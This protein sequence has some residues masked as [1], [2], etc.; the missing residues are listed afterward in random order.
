MEIYAATTA[1][2]ASKPLLLRTLASSAPTTIHR[3]QICNVVACKG[4]ERHETL[5]QWRNR[6]GRSRF[7]PVHLGSNAY[8]Q[9]S[10]LSRSRRSAPRRASLPALGLQVRPGRAPHLPWLQDF[11]VV[12][13]VSVR[14]DMNASCDRDLTLS[15]TAPP[16]PRRTARPGA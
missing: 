4:V 9:A 15:P 5:G 10:T 12:V 11:D 8:K 7:E 1:A 3:H 14:R 13:Y 6:L 16:A 2:T